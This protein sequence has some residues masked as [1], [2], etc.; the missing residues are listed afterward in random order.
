MWKLAFQ[1]RAFTKYFKIPALPVTTQSMPCERAAD[2]ISLC[3]KMQLRRTEVSGDRSTE[4]R[5]RSSLYTYCVQDKDIGT[6][7]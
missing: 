7:V 1:I 5:G 6:A 2:R 3:S 4:D